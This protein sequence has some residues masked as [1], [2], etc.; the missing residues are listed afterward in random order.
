MPAATPTPTATPTEAQVFEIPPDEPVIIYPNP[1]SS[2]RDI[3]VQ[4]DITQS[5]EEFSFKIYTVSFRLVR[6]YRKEKGIPSGLNTETISKKYLEGLGKGTYYYI[7]SLKGKEGFK[8]KSKI[9][10]LVILQ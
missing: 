3:Y 6:E 5:A 10:K 4:Y 8:A 9:G 1:A 2:K 7:I